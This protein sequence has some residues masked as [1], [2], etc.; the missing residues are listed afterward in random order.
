M[1]RAKDR[2]QTASTAAAG[3]VSSPGAATPVLIVDDL[4]Q[5][6]AL[7]AAMRAY[8]AIPHLKRLRDEVLF[9]DVCKQPGMSARDRSI[10]RCAILAALGRQDERK[11][12][13]RRAVGNSVAMDDLRRLAVPVAFYAGWPAG[14][15]VGRAVLPFLEATE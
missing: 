8:K 9:G 3:P 14:L 7:A 1:T 2:D 4:S 10:V 15:A 6:L 5:N 11:A 12:H 13:V